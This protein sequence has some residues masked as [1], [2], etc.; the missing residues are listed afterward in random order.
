[1]TTIQRGDVRQYRLVL[2]VLTTALAIATAL[3][4]YFAATRTSATA[5]DSDSGPVSPPSVGQQDEPCW[6]PN[7]PC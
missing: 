6:R 2:I 3:A 5:G 1:M 4:V 7:V